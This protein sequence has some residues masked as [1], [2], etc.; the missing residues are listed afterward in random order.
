[1]RKVNLILALCFLS[2]AAYSQ[3]IVTVSGTNCVWR[4]GDNPVWSSPA[5]DD[6]A[7]QPASAWTL[8]P[9]HSHF[10]VRCHVDISP[11]RSVSQPAVLV[12]MTS[13][14]QMFFN[15]LPGG[16]S[17]NIQS[18]H[19]SRN[20]FRVFPLPQAL[21]AR[22]AV[23]ALRVTQRD[24][25]RNALAQLQ[26][27]D[28]PSLLDRRSALVLNGIESHAVNFI[29]Y[30]II[31]VIGLVLLGLWI[32]D[33]SRRQL[34]WLTLSCLTLFLIRAGEFLNAAQFDRS[35][36]AYWLAYAIGNLSFVTQ[37]LFFFSISGRRIPRFLWLLIAFQFSDLVLNLSSLLLPPTLALPLQIFVAQRLEIWI[38]LTEAVLI[39]AMYGF[40]FLPLRTLPR[41]TRIL[42]FFCG[43]W[44]L[45]DAA[46]FAL[47]ITITRIYGI[48]DLFDRWHAVMLD[49]RTVTTL[50]AM[51]AL[52]TLLFREQRRIV[53]ERAA[54][55]AE[56]QSAQEVQKVLIPAEIPSVP[57][58]S[59]ACVYR[60]AGEVGG[61]FFQAVPIAA[62]GVLLVIGDVSGKGM[63]AAMTVSLL[64][65][66]FRTLAHYTQEPAAILAAMNQ[67]MLARS[68]GG[69]TT[70]LC[71]HVAANGV[72][73]FAN[74]GHPAPYCNRDE[75]KLDSGLPLG[76]AA[77]TTYSETTL[78]LAPG[79]TLTF[80]SDGVV[81]ARNASGELFGFERTAAISTRTADEIAHAAQAHGQQDDITVLTL[82]YAPQEEAHA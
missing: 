80:V 56:M 23:I 14:Y 46:W 42:A 66:T 77:D 69:F 19:F 31:G 2:L 21:S 61:D 49:I 35:D 59:L 17:G 16:E 25:D 71:A 24:F 8:S 34:L 54:L 48:P 65:G 82:T 67:R 1:M 32:S 26:F 47:E 5:L 15:G 74:A 76:L 28:L 60:P 62:G 78:E 22:S 7:W 53:E 20:Q 52:L 6:S 72:V 51:I 12:A 70:C 11:L 81:E 38:L 39:L 36:V 40:A 29:S 57:G 9:A 79:D 27:G 18:G 75:I 37:M 10:W 73:T 3:E 55:A 33:R 45:S 50:S 44:A 63:P 13:A 4:D 64:V 43:L 68:Q 41:P 30:G 58:F